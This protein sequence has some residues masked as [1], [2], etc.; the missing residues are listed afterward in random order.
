[1]LRTMSVILILAMAGCSSYKEAKATEYNSLT[2]AEMRVIVNK[3]TEA[4]F[5]GVYDD[6]YEPGVYTCKRCDLPLFRSEDKFKSGTGWPSFDEMI[7]QAVQQVPDGRRSEIVCARCDGHLGH[8]FHGEGFTEK[9]TRH[10]VNS[11]SLNFMPNQGK[12]S[13]IFAGGCFWGVE[14]Y[15]R[16][17][18]GVISTTVGYV[19]G[20]TDAP[21]YREVCTKRTGHAEAVEV[22]FDSTR[23]SY[24]TLA[25]LFFEIHDPTQVNRQG[26][27]IGG[28]YRSAV[29]YQD[30]EQRKVTEK[31]I[32]LLED[33]G[34]N[35]ATQVVK[36]QRFWPGEEYH[37]DYYAKNGKKPYCHIKTKR[38]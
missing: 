21:T 3:G 31:L 27:D 26:P 28:Q 36:A 22:E 20:K 2:S 37:Q 19:G 35:V 32:K 7:A 38:F 18:P 16:E 9:N 10:C 14:H 13:A 33:K 24:E 6:H 11:I 34:M 29:F 17:V 15:L 12:Q 1:M 8:V 5:S 30:E 25:R 4:P 23:V